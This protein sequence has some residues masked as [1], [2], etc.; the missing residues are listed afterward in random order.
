MTNLHL[1]KAKNFGL[2]TTLLAAMVSL[3]S[4]GG[5]GSDGYYGGNTIENPE[6]APSNISITDL[7]ATSDSLDSGASTTI[8]LKTNNISNNSIQNDITVDFNTTCGTFEP[9]VVTSSIQGDVSSTYNT[10]DVN[11]NLCE[12]VQSITATTDGGKVTKTI[13]VTIAPIEVN[14]IVYSSKAINLGIQKSGS[15]SS[16]QVEFDIF[17]NGRPVANQDVIIELVRGPEDFHFVNIN[18]RAAKTIKSGASGKVL[19]NLFPGNKPGPVEIKATLASNQNIFALSKEVAIA[20]GRVTQSGLSISLSKNSLENSKDGD[21]ASITASMVDR[22]GNPVPDGTVISFVTEGGSITPNCATTQGKCSVTLTSQDPR[23]LNN[24][25]TVLAFVEGEKSYI[26]TDGDNLFTKEVDKLISNIGDF[27]RDDNENSQ[28]DANLG[29]FIYKRGA[30][31]SICAPSTIKNPNIPATC[32]NNLEAVIR[33]QIIFAFAND[34]AI[35]DKLE[36][37]RQSFEFKIFGNT[38]RSVPMPSG[39]TVNV[40]AEDNTSTENAG[41]ENT[42]VDKTCTAELET[43]S[44]TVVSI[45]NLLTPSTFQ[46]SNQVYYR[47]R[48]KDCAVGDKI[49]LKVTAP[50]GAVTNKIYNY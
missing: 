31:G 30:E 1:Q 46:N 14:S 28:Y 5:G 10:I 8:K 13:Q 18:N 50:N 9:A 39:S 47:Y 3:A 43:G 7:T 11:G 32:D 44:E 34:D 17:S 33:E 12:G 40:E 45:F 15:A 29:E 36:S 37:S 35:I 27:F 4:C 25:A 26:D 38:D 21:S 19:V 2:T 23:P 24:R 6:N 16:G 48:L 42:V 49:K 20:T 22:V 41:G